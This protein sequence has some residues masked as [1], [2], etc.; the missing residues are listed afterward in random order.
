MELSAGE[1][2]P[3]WIVLD[4]AAIDDIDFTGGKTVAELAEQ[5]RRQGVK[6]AFADMRKAVRR[7]LGRY[8]V[9]EPFFDTVDE[10]RAAFHAEPARPA[11]S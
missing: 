9:K 8:G 4:A 1:S 6:L 7:E 10:A 2:P 5:L 3:R 11:A